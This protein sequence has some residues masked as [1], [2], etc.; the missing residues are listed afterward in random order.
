MRVEPEKL[1]E[2]GPFADLVGRPAFLKNED[3]RKKYAALR[4]AIQLAV[5]PKSIFDS[6]RVQDI[7]DYCWEAQ[8]FKRNL[9]A[10]IQSAV[11]SSLA[12]LLGGQFGDNLDE[13][14]E[15]ARNFHS[16]DPKKKRRAQQVMDR[17]GITPEK[18]EANA[19]HVRGQTVQ[20]LD[21]M[22]LSRETRRNRL[23][24]DHEKRQRKAR[25]ENRTISATD[26]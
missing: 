22:I 19:I 14:M 17:L 21:R 13:A 1:L 24:K 4:S 11:T 9:A 26:K 7:T 6:M 3:E 25:K 16:G 2:E 5:N 10:L 15:T 20:M 12:A 18:I 8:Y 23:I